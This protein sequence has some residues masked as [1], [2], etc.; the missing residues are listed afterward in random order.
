MYIDTMPDGHTGSYMPCQLPRAVGVGVHRTRLRSL[1][2][3]LPVP[4]PDIRPIASALLAAAVPKVVLSNN[5]FAAG[6]RLPGA[7]A[8]RGVQLGGPIDPGFEEPP[9]AGV[10]PNI[11][12]ELP[13]RP[14]FARRL[15]DA[16]ADNL[17]DNASRLDGAAIWKGVLGG[18]ISSAG[19]SDLDNIRGVAFRVPH[20][21]NCL[22][23]EGPSSEA[24]GEGRLGTREKLLLVGDR[25]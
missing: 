15:F 7:S 8:L 1:S 5:L 12:V 16:L 13:R 10:R 18:G 3:V 23:A 4:Q 24:V 19:S 6:V 9:R 17:C 14:A 11:G 20:V 22:T 21:I 2:T 25:G